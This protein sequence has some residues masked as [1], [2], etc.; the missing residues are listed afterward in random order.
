MNFD[1]QFNLS[2]GPQSLIAVPDSPNPGHKKAEIELQTVKCVAN[3]G[4]L[5]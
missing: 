1:C 3:C 5:D 2:D 4:K